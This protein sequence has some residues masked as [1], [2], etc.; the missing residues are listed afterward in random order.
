LSRER[1]RESHIVGAM[2]YKRSDRF[3]QFIPERRA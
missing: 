1:E 3:K 2:T